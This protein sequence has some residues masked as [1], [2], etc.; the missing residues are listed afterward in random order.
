MKCFQILNNQVLIINENQQYTDTCENFVQDGGSLSYQ[1]DNETITLTKVIY[2][3]QQKCC[4]VG[5]DFLSYPD[6]QFEDNINGIAAF[7]A[8]KEEREYKEPTQADKNKEMAS[9]AKSKLETLAV[10]AMMAQLAGGDIAVQ[11]EEYQSNIATLSDD[12]ALLIPEVYPA[13]D[14]NGVEYK[15]NDRVIYNGTLYKVLTAHTSEETW[16]PTDAPSLFVKVLTSTEGVPN[17]EQP[18]A[19]NAYM[20]GDRVR[21]NGK[22]YES[23][24]DNN[25]WS[26]DGYPAGWQEIPE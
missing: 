26:P 11:K 9:T 2:D 7:I 23:L 21:Y 5:D 20:K 10:N 19:D 18:S 22:I 14:G 3:D 12:V 15:K 17:W 25:V 16:T 1:K 4:V 8:A 6:S 13:W 24:I